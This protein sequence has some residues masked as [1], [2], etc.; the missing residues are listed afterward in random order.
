MPELTLTT[1]LAWFGVLA[2]A[3]SVAGLVFGLMGAWQTKRL[4]A[5][6]HA[7]TQVTVADVAKGFRESQEALGK[8]FTQGQ[9]ALGEA[10]KGIGQ[11][12][13]QLGQ[14]LERIVQRADERQ[15]EMI[16]AIQA[17]KR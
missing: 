4:Q 11:G 16:Q 7:A 12:V 9:Q 3:A 1:A 10:L 14:V 13:T 15:R 17:L 8:G 2:C 6:I 5:D